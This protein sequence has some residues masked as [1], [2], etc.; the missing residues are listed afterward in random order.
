VLV[1]TA[2]DE[3][4]PDRRA[5]FY[6]ANAENT[7]LHH[8]VGMSAA[9][10]AAVDDFTIGAE[11]LA[12]GLAMHTGQPVL[13]ADVTKDPRGEQWWA[14]AA[15]FDYR[16]CWSFPIHSLAGRFVGT[17]AVYSRQPREAT[18]RDLEFASLLTHTA[19]MII[20]RHTES[21]ARKQAE[22][23]PIEQVDLLQLSSDAI[24]VRDARNHITHWSQGA[25]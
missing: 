7:S 20:A 11:S 14:M 15:R 9:Y 13:I 18:G 19:S 2:T 4:G 21:A 6:L 8:V 10:A 3:L 24:I 1:K 5:A 22:Q 12:P 25:T 16:G 23:R 17:F